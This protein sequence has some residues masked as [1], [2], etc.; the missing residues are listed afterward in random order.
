MTEPQAFVSLALTGARFEQLGMPVDTLP[1]LAAYRELLIQ[2]ARAVFRR[3]YPGRVRVPRGFAE[4]FQLR[5]LEVRKGSA[6]PVLERTRQDPSDPLFVAH[7]DI[8][9]DARDVIEDTIRELSTMGRTPESFPE[10]ALADLGRFGRTL[11]PGEAIHIGKPG[12]RSP[13]IYTQLTRRAFLKSRGQLFPAEASVS[14]VITE[15]SVERSTFTLR[16][17]DRLVFCSYEPNNFETI[18]SN[19]KPPSSEGSEV[20]VEG[21]AFVDAEDEPVRFP[22]V[23]RIFSSESDSELDDSVDTPPVATPVTG[24][25]LSDLLARLDEIAALEVGWLD[26]EGA[27][28]DRTVISNVRRLLSTLADNPS[29]RVCVYPTE[30]GGVQLEWTNGPIESS[31]EFLTEGQVQFSFV[32]VESGQEGSR[33]IPID[34]H[35]GMIAAICGEET[36]D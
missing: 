21:F 23:S 27:K 22:I 30:A 5:L 4:S 14:G 10:F 20:T 3:R 8:F 15:I 7:G 34:D 29:P 32:D 2:V 12:G 28:I 33:S 1:E 35:A 26:G 36:G 11:Q 19:L 9:E 6:V 18:R 31:L 25:D 16:V 24:R 17:S 13:A